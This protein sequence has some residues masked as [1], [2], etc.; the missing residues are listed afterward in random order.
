MEQRQIVGLKI[1]F[2]TKDRLDL[3]YWEWQVGCDGSSGVCIGGLLFAARMLVS[4]GC[5]PL[6]VSVE[7]LCCFLPC[8]INVNLY[9]TSQFISFIH[10]KKLFLKVGL[11]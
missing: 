8:E 11:D 7:C 10:C 1:I 2:T 9:R 5:S 6:W 3:A 4:Q